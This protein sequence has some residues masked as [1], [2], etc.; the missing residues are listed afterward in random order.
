MRKYITLFLLVLSATAFAQKAEFMR[1][2]ELN[3]QKKYAE[4]IVLFE[5]LLNKQ[6]G[7][8]DEITQTYCMALNAGSYYALNNFKTAYEKYDEELKFLRTIKKEDDKN[9]KALVKFMEELKLKIPEEQTAAKTTPISPEANTPP[10]TETQSNSLTDSD[11]LKTRAT[12]TVKAV[13]NE[14]TL[15]LTVTASGK[16]IEEAKNNALRAALE[17]AFGAF[18]SSKTEILNDA[19]VKD[20]I[21]SVANGNIQ[22]YELISQV[23]IPNNGYGITLRATVS[24]DKLTTFA[25][26]KGVVVEFKGGLFAQNIKLQKINEQNE[27][28][29]CINL[30]GIVHELMQNGF[31]YTVKTAEPKVYKE[32]IYNLKFVVQTKPNANFTN[33]TNYLINSLKKLAMAKDEVETYNNLNKK[34]YNYK[35]FALRNF[36]SYQTLENIDNYQYYYLGNFQ[37]SINDDTKINGPDLGYELYWNSNLNDLGVE[38]LPGFLQECRG[39]E[40]NDPSRPYKGC[41]S[42][43]IDYQDSLYTYYWSQKFKLTELETIQKISVANRGIRSKF[44]YGGFVIYSDSTKLIVAAPYV[45]NYDEVLKWPVLKTSAKLFDAKA[46]MTLF[47]AQN[48]TNTIYDVLSNLN[49]RH[50]TDWLIPTWEELKLLKKEVYGGKNY[51]KEGSGIISST[52]DDFKLY[53]WYSPEIEYVDEK[54]KEEFNKGIPYN[55]QD[56]FNLLNGL[57]LKETQYMNQLRQTYIIVNLIKYIKLK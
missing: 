21:V 29:A 25:E 26:S 32:D 34:V 42:S 41:N 53:S 2:Y 3:N 37:V 20:E 33:A 48:S 35:G 31:D 14:K 18:V 43:G 28:N 46:N 36:Y 6:Y 52:F 50:N 15:T 45:V 17:Q 24:I 49:I 38:A 44:Q 39:D 23:E 51:L 47:K 4:A 54:H 5:Q 9:I 1:A 55:S 57:K 27:L 22:K 13:S 12:D 56:S 11:T 40:L 19:V 10:K 7:P 30:F 8:L 16:T